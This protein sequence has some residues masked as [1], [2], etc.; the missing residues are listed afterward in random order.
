MDNPNF[1]AVTLKNFAAP[2]TNRDQSVFVPL[3]DYITLVMGMVRDNVPFN[4][5][6]SGNMLYVRPACRRRRRRT[7]TRTS[8]RSR[9]RMREPGFNQS[10]LA[11]T[12]QT[13][14]YGTPAAATAGAITTR[15]AVRGVLHRGHEPR[16]VPLHADEPHV[17]GHGAGARHE[18]P[19]GSHSPR[20]VAQPRRRQPRVLEQLHR[21]PRGH[22]S[23]GAGVRLLRLRHDGGS[24]RLQHDA[25]CTRSTSTT[26]RRS[27]TASSRRTT[28]GTTTGG[29]VRT[30]YSA[31][32]RRCP[33]KAAARSRSAKSSP[34]TQ[35]FASAKSR[36]CS[37][38]FACATPVDAADR[39]QIDAMTNSF[40]EQQL[41]PEASVRRSPPAI[42]WAT[43]PG[44][45]GS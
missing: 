42:A 30:R 17:H 2:W 41:Q 9:P 39:D 16:D 20:R 11:Q 6:L 35:A 14:I 27:R 45:S 25:R 37:K 18:H 38:L 36:R 5:I 34:A 44:D 15:A 26:T 28:P 4:Q 23:A 13:A 31:G 8:R 12:T 10:E 29:R 24:D 3:N 43:S 22:G 32:T 33:A 19:A 7:A 1:Y 40:R 21:L